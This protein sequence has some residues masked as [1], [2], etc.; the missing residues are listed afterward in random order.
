MSAR[1]IIIAAPASGAGKTTIVCGLLRAFRKRGLRT[2][3][4]KVGPDFIDPAFH[5]V[6]SGQPCRNIDGW[7]MR[8]ET[9]RQQ[10]SAAATGADIVIIEGVMGLFDGSASGEGSTADIAALLDLPIMLVLDVRAQS[11]SAA[12][13]ALGF[14]RYRSDIQVIGVILNRLAGDRHRSMIEPAFERTGLKVLGGLKRNEALELPSRHLGLVQAAEHP[15]LDTFLDE[16]AVAVEQSLNL[17]EI[18]RCARP[19]ETSGSSPSVGLAPLGRHIAIARDE[20]FAFSYPHLIE[21]WREQNATVSYFSPLADEPP[22]SAADSVYLPGGYPEL[23]SARL[24][25]GTQWKSSLHA[26][27]ERGRL[28]YGECG[29]FMALGAELIDANGSSHAMAGLLP[30]VSSFAA[31][32]LHMG[33]RVVSFLKPL[34]FAREG[35]LLRGHEFHYATSTQSASCESLLRTEGETCGLVQGSVCGSFIHLIDRENTAGS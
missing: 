20:A 23:H 15:R 22:D 33:Y 10:V 30:L 27:A 8:P 3:A 28:I 31:R 34:P 5:A 9:L 17:D 21:A 26:M 2:A 4:L 35:E 16:A 24:A 18:L 29:G 32:R 12:A 25:A 19:V 6:A 14:A 1:A 7:A 13:V 11:A